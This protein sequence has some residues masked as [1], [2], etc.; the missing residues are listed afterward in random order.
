MAITKRRATLAP[1]IAKPSPGARECVPRCQALATR[2][3][4]MPFAGSP[5]TSSISVCTASVS[6]PFT[7]LEDDEDTVGAMT[8]VDIVWFLSCNKGGPFR[9]PRPTPVSGPVDPAPDECARAA[10][11]SSGRRVCW[12]NAGARH[13][14]GCIESGRPRAASAGSDKVIAVGSGLPLYNPVDCPDQLDQLVD[15]HIARRIASAGIEAAPLQFVHDC[16]LAFLLPVKE[17][18]V[19]VKFRQIGILANAFAIVGLREQL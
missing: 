11:R 13:R 10:R 18:D 14:R 6:M 9:R 7:M 1:P 3:W 2:Q 5:S 4:V 15:R 16:V 19:L 17:K 12:R 8:V